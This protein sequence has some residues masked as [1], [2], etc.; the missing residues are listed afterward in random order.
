MCCASTIFRVYLGTILRMDPDVDPHCPN[1]YSFATIDA[2]DVEIVTTMVCLTHRRDVT[3][4]QQLRGSVGTFGVAARASPV[5]SR[6]SHNRQPAHGV[7]SDIAVLYPGCLSLLSAPRTSGQ[8][9]ICGHK[10]IRDRPPFLLIR[11]RLRE[12]SF[13][14]WPP[15]HT[16]M[17]YHRL[18]QPRS[19]WNPI[20]SV[21]PHFPDVDSA[22]FLTIAGVGAL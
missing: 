6:A 4:P 17:R 15:N 13:D 7:Q 8:R 2:V 10:S 19:F 18:H 9:G 20:V 3:H 12:N 14:R 16:C 11:L 22:Y 5:A 1:S 21:M